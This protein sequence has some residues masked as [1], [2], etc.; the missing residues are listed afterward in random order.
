MTNYDYVKGFY[1]GFKVKTRDNGK[2]YIVL[3][4]KTYKDVFREIHGTDMFPDDYRYKFISGLVGALLDYSVDLNEITGPDELRKAFEGVEHEIID[5]LVPVYNF[6]RTT[7]LN[8]NLR[9]GQY[10]DEAE[11]EGL[12]GENCDIFDRIA[13]GMYMEIQELYNRTIDEIG[14]RSHMFY[15][16]EE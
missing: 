2:E 8:S 10:C 6:E 15:M 9:R 4:D 12:T 1:D 16:C 5:G 7:W 3:E 14:N 13:A 11:D